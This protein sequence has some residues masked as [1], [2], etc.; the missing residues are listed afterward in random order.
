MKAPSGRMT[1]V[2]VMIRPRPLVLVPK[3]L[4]IVG[5]DIG[6]QQEVEGIEGPAEIACRDDMLLRRTPALER[7]E[8]HRVPP[9]L[10]HP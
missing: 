3:D 10:L 8:S 7:F 1:S 2:A 5:R 4:A 9:D 6:D